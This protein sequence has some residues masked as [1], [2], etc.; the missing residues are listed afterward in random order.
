MRE[1]FEL[2]DMVVQDLARPRPTLFGDSSNFLVDCEGSVR[3]N[4][5]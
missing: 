1:Q 5:D 2:I 3:R 4:F